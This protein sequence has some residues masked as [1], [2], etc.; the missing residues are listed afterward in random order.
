MLALKYIFSKNILQEYE[1]QIC[2][3]EF[4]IVS[5][6]IKVAQSYFNCCDY[7][8]STTNRPVSVALLMANAHPRS[9]LDS[10]AYLTPVSTI[11]SE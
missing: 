10:Q 4:F 9:L 11:E 5:A 3:I 8:S 6:R 7:T 1:N 2:A